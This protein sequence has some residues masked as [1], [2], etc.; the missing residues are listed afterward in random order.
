M[1]ALAP[2]SGFRFSATGEDD[3][4]MGDEA[5]AGGRSWILRAELPRPARLRLL[6]DGIEVRG[7]EGMG[8]E[9]EAEGAGV[10][11]VEASLEAKGR[12]RTWIL[13]NPIYLR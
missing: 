1:D 5:P 6:R 13:S 2:A 7:N 8:I 11:R 3:L 10:Y 4:I 9:H 12:E